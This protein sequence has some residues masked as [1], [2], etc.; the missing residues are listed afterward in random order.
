MRRVRTALSLLEVLVA[1]ALII[2][3]V[4]AMFTFY[5]QMAE[6]R[7]KAAEASSR[8]Q[9]ARVIVDEIAREIR[10][11]VGFDKIN[12]PSAQGEQRIVGTRRTLSFFTTALPGKDQ[13]MFYGP[14]DNPLPAKHDLRLI[15]Y[16]L[17]VDPHEKNENGDPIVGG[18]LR[19][20]KKTLN[21][22]LVNED[23]P[24]DIRN[25]L[26]SPELG[27]LEFRYFDGVEWDTKWDITDGNSLPQ[28][29][30]VTVGYKSI[31][32]EELDDVDLQSFS[33]SDYPFGDPK[34]R[35]DRYSVIVKI[36]AA[37][38]FFSSRIS[39]VGKQASDQL[40]VTGEAV[41]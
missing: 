19:S 22:F 3:L 9:L 11:M 32:Q 17:W 40:G 10:G 14:G 29:I 1:L 16:S 34:P 5:W 7:Q 8:T 37:D 23:D 2:M 21:Q 15:S 24:L 28:L 13:Y 6:A 27:Y 39:R 30:M 25:D 41:K 4:S 35:D 38:R 33:L 36:P 18:I 31:T 26:Q 20:E 12:F